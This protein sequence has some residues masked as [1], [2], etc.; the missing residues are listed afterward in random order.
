MLAMM[1]LVAK[2]GDLPDVKSWAD[3]TDEAEAEKALNAT[4]DEFIMLNGKKYGVQFS[5][6]NFKPE[7]KDEYTGEV[8]PRHLVRKAMIEELT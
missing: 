1:N 4:T 3:L 8:L 2:L 7:Y 6:A 5:D